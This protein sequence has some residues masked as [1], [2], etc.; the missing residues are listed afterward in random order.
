MSV[1][2]FANYKFIC[3]KGTP[4]YNDYLFLLPHNPSNTTENCTN[5]V[6]WTKFCMSDIYATA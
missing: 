2:Y 1:V 5:L 3:N 4:N 6:V